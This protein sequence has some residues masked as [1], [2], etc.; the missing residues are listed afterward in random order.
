MSSMWNNVKIHGDGR[1]LVQHPQIL[2]VLDKV[3]FLYYI[4]KV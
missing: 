2:P 1:H 3:K 4:L